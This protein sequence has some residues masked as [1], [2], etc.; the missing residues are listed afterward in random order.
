M[1]PFKYGLVIFCNLQ[2]ND[3]FAPVPSENTPNEDKIIYEWIG[4]LID[5]KCPAE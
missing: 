5:K 2:C 3:V 4:S 1:D